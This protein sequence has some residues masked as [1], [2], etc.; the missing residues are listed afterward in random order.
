MRQRERTDRVGRKARGMKRKWKV[1]K[2]DSIWGSLQ[3]ESHYCCTNLVCCT[4]QVYSLEK[5]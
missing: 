3:E 5:V 4:V 2:M 1:V